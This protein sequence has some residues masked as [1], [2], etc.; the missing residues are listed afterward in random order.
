MPAELSTLIPGRGSELSDAQEIVA[1]HVE[2]A[3]LARDALGHAHAARELAELAIAPLDKIDG[4][5]FSTGVADSIGGLAGRDGL[6]HDFSFWFRFR[7]LNTLLYPTIGI[8]QA[9]F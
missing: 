2:L 4:E 5:D 7:F 8:C 9:N 6:I 1:C 3:T